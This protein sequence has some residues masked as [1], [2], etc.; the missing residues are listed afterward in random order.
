MRTMPELCSLPP[1]HKELVEEVGDG[2]FRTG[3][4]RLLNHWNETPTKAEEEAAR[5]E[6]IQERQTELREK[7]FR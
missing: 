2:S 3:V 6:A 7:L 4:I 1:R 5:E